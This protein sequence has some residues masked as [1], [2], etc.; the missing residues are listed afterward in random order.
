MNKK[1]LTFDLNKLHIIGTSYST[2]TLL[3]GK[4]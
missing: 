2:T 4:S 3:V 1:S